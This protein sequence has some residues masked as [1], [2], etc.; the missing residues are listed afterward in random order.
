MVLRRRRQPPRRRRCPWSRARRRSLLLPRRR[1]RK[2]AHRTMIMHAKLLKC[3]TVRAPPGGSPLAPPRPL[4]TVLARS[5]SGGKRRRL[6]RPRR[7]WSMA[8]PSFQH[9]DGEVVDKSMSECSHRRIV[10]QG[11]A[12]AANDA[13]MFPRHADRSPS[14][15]D[16]PPSRPGCR[17]REKA[18]YGRGA[19]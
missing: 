18:I 4:A 7:K 2:W 12:F 14:I 16:D 5:S 10:A 15:D 11:I 19:R 13:L 17:R 6:R 8:R 3:T 1:Y 9:A